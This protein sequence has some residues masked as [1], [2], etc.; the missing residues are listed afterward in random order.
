MTL[1]TAASPALLKPAKASRKQLV[2]VVFAGL[3]QY[4]ESA[5]R[6]YKSEEKINSA[7]YEGFNWVNTNHIELLDFSKAT[8]IC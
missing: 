7:Y 4:L 2:F 5:L 6:D 1:F 8:F 3:R